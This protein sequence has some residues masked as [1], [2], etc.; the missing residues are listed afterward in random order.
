MPEEKNDIHL[1]AY[2]VQEMESKL[3][4]VGDMIASKLDTLTSKYDEF[5]KEH[6]A[7]QVTLSHY[8]KEIDALKEQIAKLQEQVFGIRLTMAE[9][10]AYGFGGGAGG[11][12]LIELIRNLIASLS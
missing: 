8:K 5:L 11:A 7:N 12:L 10:I 2:R 1:L 4:S 3:Q 6:I 9:R